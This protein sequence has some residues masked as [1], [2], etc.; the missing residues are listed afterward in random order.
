MIHYIQP[1]TIPQSEA[2]FSQ[3][4][5]DD[6]YA[7]LAGV[8]AA[9]FPEGRAVLGDVGRETCAVLTV[10][11]SMLQ[12]IGLDMTCIVRTDVHLVN[13]DDFD[14]M[15]AAYRGFFGNGR[16]PARTTTESTRLFGGSRVEITCMARLTS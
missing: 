4:V 14:D 9:D 7:H 16:Y 5:M 1:K 8:V 6:T 11:R 2:P 15:D 12:E 3:I 13:L 10:I